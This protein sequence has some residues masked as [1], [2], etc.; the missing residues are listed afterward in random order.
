MTTYTMIHLT[1]NDCPV[2]PRSQPDTGN[3]NLVAVSAQSVV[4]V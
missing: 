2:V 3:I 4:R 1:A